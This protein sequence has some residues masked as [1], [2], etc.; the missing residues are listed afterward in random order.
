MRDIGIRFCRQDSRAFE[1]TAEP[2]PAG[3]SG[4]A[5]GGSDAAACPHSHE[6]C[7]METKDQVRPETN[8]SH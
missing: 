5:S 1:S 7:P 2:V 4:C 3:V 6:D 8:V